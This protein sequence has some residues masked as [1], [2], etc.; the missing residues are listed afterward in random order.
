MTLAFVFPGQ[1][2]QSV[3]MLSALAAEHREV[4]ATFAEASGVLGYDLWALVQQGPEQQLNSTEC[5][6]PAMLAAGIAVW[7]VWRQAGGPMPD[8][9]AGHS[10]GEFTALVAAGA[11]DFAAA[12]DLVRWRGRFM[13]EAVPAGEGAVAAVLGLEP[14]VVA[15]VCAEAALGQVVEPV[16]FNAPGQIVI[17]GATAA[18]ER[19]IAAAKGRGARRAVLLPVSAPVHSSLMRGAARRLEER[20]AGIAIRRPRLRFLSS[21][22][23]R[24]RGDPG[25]IRALLIRQLASPVRW[26]DMIKAITASAPVTLVECGPGRVLTGLNRRIDRRPEVH[27]LSVEDPAT[28]ATALDGLRTPA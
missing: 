14:A 1:G 21:V 19:A 11:L 24:E 9:V 16:N 20:L 23:A 6:Q 7:R 25:A 28:L 17:A 3:G 18:V 13:Q 10:L 4:V 15:A 27:C 8:L 5:T 26:I 22:D 12:V 2:S